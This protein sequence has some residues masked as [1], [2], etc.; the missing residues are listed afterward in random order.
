MQLSERASLG[1]APLRVMVIACTRARQLAE[2][3]DDKRAVVAV[4][5]AAAMQQQAT[6]SS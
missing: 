4:K 6:A 1:I 2:A 3:S 5:V